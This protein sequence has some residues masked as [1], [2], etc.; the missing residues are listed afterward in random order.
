MKEISMDFFR[1]EVRNGFF[2]P[3]AVKQAW[4]AQLQVLDVIETICRK[5][6]ITYFADWGTILG[7]VR[8]GGYVPWDD[9][10]DICMKREDYT[11]FKEAAKT[12]LPKDF[13]IHDY[14]HQEDHWLFLSRVANSVHI[15]F[16]PEHMKQFHNFPYIAGIDIFVLDYLYKDEQQEKQRCEEVKHIIAVADSIIA[17][18]IAQPVKEANLIQLEEKYH[19]TFNRKLD[20]RHMGIELYRLA[21]EQMARVPKEES[22]RMAQIFP[23]GL[24][25]NRGQDREYYEKFVRLPFE[26]TTMPVPADYHRILS[27]KYHDYFKI[28]KV[29]SGH[30]YPYFEGQRKNLQVVADFKLPEFTFDKAMLRQN[31]K[32]MKN[33]DTMQNIAAEALLNIEKLHKAFKAEMQGKTG[34]VVAGSEEADDTEQSKSEAWTDNAGQRTGKLSVD[35]TAK[36]LDILAQC[37]GVAIDLGNFI[38]QMK[39]EENLSAKACVAALEEYCE[40]IFNVY[41][42][43][44]LALGREKEDFQKLCAALNQAFVQMKQTVENEIIHKKL[45]AFLPDNP[46]R[47]KEMQALYDYYRQQENTEVCVIP[48]PLFAKNLYGEIVAGQDEYD[49]NDKRGE[50]PADLNIIAWHT[51]QMQSYE[52]AAIVIQNPYDAENPYLTVPPAYYAKQLQQYT[53]CLIYMMPQGVNDFTEYDITDIYGLK[54]SLTVPGAMYADKILIESGAMKELFVN[55]LTA[56]AGKDTRA[57]WNEKIQIIGA[58]TGTEDLKENREDGA[59]ADRTGQMQTEQKKTLLYCI[60]ENEFFENTAAALDKVKE[61]L[62]VITQYQDSLKA[63]VC[64]YPYDIAMWDIVSEQEKENI[65]RVLKEYQKNKNIEFLSENT[66]DIDRMTAYYGSPSPLICRFVEQ[67]KPAMV[68]E[69]SFK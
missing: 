69:S 50:Y 66:I 25:G 18:E 57:V 54:Y 15:N 56:F 67:H 68:S 16:E 59:Q 27:G 1:D 3:T 8:H 2:I 55:H 5:H 62:D 58:F 52:F 30:D 64:L 31:T 47:W 37:Q 60:G 4:A 14:E 12:E 61:R 19:K 38:E 48:L 63:A 20:N 26:N 43:L 45:V 32:E 35:S 49:K 6:D 28:H 17:G 42:N 44:S 33:S 34:S 41:N 22:D 29:W 21:E 53:D 23:W 39:G 65:V 40:K 24:L 13:R 51:V 10:M 46:K 36:M 11:R 9:D 7:T